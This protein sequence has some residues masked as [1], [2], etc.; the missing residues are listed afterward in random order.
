MEKLNQV[1]LRVHREEKPLK[2]LSCE[3]KF[4]AELAAIAKQGLLVLGLT[5]VSVLFTERP[6]RPSPPK[7][8]HIQQ[9]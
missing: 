7:H 2:C 8:K 5:K 1:F 6:R 4:K 9:Q 3:E